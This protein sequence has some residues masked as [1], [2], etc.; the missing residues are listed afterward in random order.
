MNGYP[1]DTAKELINNLIG[2]L[3]ETDSFNVILFSGAT[4][5]LSPESLAANPFNIRKAI[6]L[7]EKQKGGGGTELAPALRQALA[8][9]LDENLARTVITITDGYIASENDIFDIIRKNLGNA[10]FFSFGIGSSVNRHL[11]DGIA[12]AGQGEAFVVTQMDEAI[13]VAEKFRVYVELPLLTDIKITYNGFEAY[14]M[15][16]SNIP[17][18]FAQRPI[19][20]FGKWSGEPTGTIEITGRMGNEDFTQVINVAD[21]TPQDTNTALSYLWA[22]E[23]VATLTNYGTAWNLNSADQRKVTDLGLKYSMLTDYT[24]FVAVVET[25][26]NESGEGL[27]VNQP[28]PLPEGVSNLAVGYVSVPEPGLLLL[29]FGVLLTV[30]ITMFREKRRKLCWEK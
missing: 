21:V 20:I 11:I 9:P 16:P 24:S 30:L 29:I 19:T 1:L 5:L 28:L 8:I 4:E 23:R 14:A 18:L 26:R 13:K 25:V 22:G 3:N 10:S 6:H 27:D 7:I 15:E 12:R 2:S 17:T